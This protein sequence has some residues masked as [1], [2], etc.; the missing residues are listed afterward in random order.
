MRR[1]AA[2]CAALALA[3]LLVAAPAAP[4][5]RARWDTRVL[6]L[7]PSPGFPAMAYV[8]PNGRIYE[9]T[10]DNP[11]GDAIRSRVFEYEGDGTLLRSWTIAGQDLS[12]PH[13]VQVATSDAQGRLI[14]LD[15]SPP[16]ALRLDRRTGAQSPYAGFP[17][18]SIPNYGAWGPDGS[19]YVTDYGKPIIWRIPP[20]G[21]TPQQ[22]LSDPRLDGGEFGTTGIALQADRKTLLVAQQSE[23]GGAGGNPSTGRL[24][25]LPIG[26]DGKA[27]ALREV[28]ASGPAD[29][30]DGFGIAQSGHV[31]IAL[32]GSNQI[33]VVGP[34]G[35]ERER[36]PSQP[37]GGGNGSSVPFDSPSSVRFLGT[38]LI[39]A[40]QSYISGD[41]NKQAVLDV[42]V[43]ET[44]LPEFI[45]GLDLTAPVISR[46]SFKPKR[47]RA[48]RRRGTRIRFRLS[49]AAT[50]TFVI[51]RRRGRRWV[52]SASFTRKRRSGRT[53]LRFSGRVRVRKRLRTLRAGRYRLTLSAEDAAGNDS[54]RVSRRFRIVR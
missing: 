24:F 46:A 47:F 3:V 14:L 4:A 54:K 44:G 7:V 35:K 40:N 49:E 34:D 36:F 39:V 13:G 41:P 2:G 18:G 53:S 33:A 15:K 38:R 43:G 10:Y 31:Y 48:G 29:G 28:W 42:E 12:Q 22:W 1:A 51:E 32:L 19:L 6:A 37:G 26:A 11:A 16:R 8:A 27:G 25:A 45:P 17:A 23:A 5:A 9:G 52:R 20:G 30:P 21:G 50:V